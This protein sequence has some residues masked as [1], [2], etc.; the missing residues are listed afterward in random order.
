MTRF[1]EFDFGPRHRVVTRT[2]RFP[3]VRL[4][5]SVALF[6]AFVVMLLAASGLLAKAHADVKVTTEQAKLWAQTANNV[7]RDYPKATDACELREAI[8]KDLKT[9]G[10]CWNAKSATPATLWVPCPAAKAPMMV[11]LDQALGQCAADA[12]KADTVTRLRDTMVPKRLA[13]DWGYPAPMV[14]AI[15][16]GRAYSYRGAAYCYSLDNIER[17]RARGLS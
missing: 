6:V 15:Y 12:Q 5:L 10:I 2:Y 3:W 14:D 11:S 9:K 16:S 7:C 4:A 1:I 17:L 8:L 13:L